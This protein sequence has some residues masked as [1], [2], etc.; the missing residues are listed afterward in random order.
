M[1]NMSYC[2]F[3]NTEID[4]IDC[5]EALEEFDV[6]SWGRIRSH[7]GYVPRFH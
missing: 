2:R 5:L 3:R 1:G 6:Q 7:E 4:L